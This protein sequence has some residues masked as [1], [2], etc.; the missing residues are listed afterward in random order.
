MH[1]ANVVR[2]G[3]RPRHSTPVNILGASPRHSG[4]HKPVAGVG[5]PG[6]PHRKLGDR[7]TGLG[8]AGYSQDEASLGDRTQSV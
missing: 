3:P 6:L 5:D 8:E 4:E 7:G 1:S 2:H